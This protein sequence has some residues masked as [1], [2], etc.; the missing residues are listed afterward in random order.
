MS[1]CSV[2]S[3]H[4]WLSHAGCVGTVPQTETAQTGVPLW[5]EGCWQQE[6]SKS[7]RN[8]DVAQQQWN[9]LEQG[10]YLKVL[11]LF[12]K[13]SCQQ[14][15]TSPLHG[16]NNHCIRFVK[17]ALDCQ[18][19]FK[20]CKSKSCTTVPSGSGMTV[21][22]RPGSFSVPLWSVLPW[23]QTRLQREIMFR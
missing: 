20:D 22:V 16:T 1:K 3:C 23:Y 17:T 8:S 18:C 10:S 13:I 7:T 4:I 19:P 2:S 9:V 11:L 5:E 6:K 15:S 14:E 12:V 21:T